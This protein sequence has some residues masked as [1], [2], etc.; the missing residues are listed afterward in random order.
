MRRKKQKALWLNVKAV[1]ASRLVVSESFFSSIV[2]CDS[3][4]EPRFFVS[5][6]YMF[7]ID[8]GTCVCTHEC[9]VLC[10]CVLLSAVTFS[11]P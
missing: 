1:D 7:L 8:H 2:V 3:F 9:V 4:Q 11:R 5:L 10:L 6:G